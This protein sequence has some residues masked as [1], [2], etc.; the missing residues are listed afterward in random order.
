MTFLSNLFDKLNSLNLSLQGPSE[1]IVVSSQ[2][3]S[4]SKKLLWQSK[5]S[6]GV[7]NCFPTDNKCASNK[8]ITPKILYTLTHLQ[9]ALQLFFSTVV[10]NKYGWVSYPFGNYEA[11]NLTTVEEE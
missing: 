6:K 5:I 2:L 1:N 3:K 8:E 4:F 10:N 9:S 11:T 7:F